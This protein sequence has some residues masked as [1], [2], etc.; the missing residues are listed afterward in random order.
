VQRDD[1]GEDSPE[2]FRALVE[3]GDWALWSKRMDDAAEIYRLALAELGD[4]DGAQ[5]EQQRAFGEPVPLPDIKGLRTLPPTVS[6]DEGNMLV[7]FRVD[8]RGRVTDLERLDTNAEID[9]AADRLLR[10]LRNTRF[11]PRFEAGQLAASD[12][13]VRAYEIKP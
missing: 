11:R 1:K 3:L 2:A 13:L 8:D 4:R 9:S 6:A 12:K 7:E 10:L 5:E